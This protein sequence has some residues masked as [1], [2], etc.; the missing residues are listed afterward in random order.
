MVSGSFRETLMRVIR[1]IRL[2]TVCALL[3]PLAASA[4]VRLPNLF[5]DHA[6]LQRDRPVRIWGSAT[7]GEHVTIRFHGQ[8]VSTRSDPMGNWEAWLTP[9]P[10]G[11]PYTLAVSS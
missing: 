11:G 9:E 1:F 4:A 10:A 7:A 2:Y 6:V 5:S 8:T 3:L